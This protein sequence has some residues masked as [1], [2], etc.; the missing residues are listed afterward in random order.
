MQGTQ[1]R[2]IQLNSPRQWQ[3]IFG[4]PGAFADHL[5]LVIFLV[6]FVCN[7]QIYYQKATLIISEVCNNIWLPVGRHNITQ[8]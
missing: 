8:M 3:D 6:S 7:K 2:S 1:Y 4:A 5:S